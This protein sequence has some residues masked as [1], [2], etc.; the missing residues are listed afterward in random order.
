MGRTECEDTMPHTSPLTGITLVWVSDIRETP[1]GF[2][3]D[4][5]YLVDPACDVLPDVQCV[6]ADIFKPG[7]HAIWQPYSDGVG[8]ENASSYT[9]YLRVGCIGVE[10]NAAWL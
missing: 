10:V 4:E 3:R 8:S 7:E 2:V 9:E 5:L 1:D 6:R